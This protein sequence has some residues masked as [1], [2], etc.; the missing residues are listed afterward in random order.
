MYSGASDGEVATHTPDGDGIRK[1]AP[2][3]PPADTYILRE[4]KTQPMSD[5][6]TISLSE[7]LVKELDRRKDPETSYDDL[8]WDLLARADSANEDTAAEGTPARRGSDPDR[9]QIRRMAEEMT[10]VDAADV[11]EIFET[12]DEPREG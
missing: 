6:T 12:A 4:T 3:L 10:H 7:A 8:L 9:E 2:P 1:S 5:E 11:D